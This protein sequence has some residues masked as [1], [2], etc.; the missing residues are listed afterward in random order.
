MTEPSS[1][2]PAPVVLVVEPAPSPVTDGSYAALAA[3]GQGLLAAELARR[4]SEAGAI[5]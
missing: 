4:F 5:V 1:E 3:R 2:R